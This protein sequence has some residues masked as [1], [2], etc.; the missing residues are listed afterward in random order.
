MLELRPSCENCDKALPPESTLAMICTYECTFCQDCVV[1]VLHNVCPNCG[2]GFQQRPIRPREQLSK[3]PASS[4]KIYKPIKV[5]PYMDRY[6]TIPP[7][8]RWVFDWFNSNP[9]KELFHNIFDYHHHFNQEIID[10]YLKHSTEIS[11]RSVPLLSHM[12][13]AHQIWNAR[14][15]N[16]K[17]LPVHQVHS[18]ESCHSIDQKNHQITI[19][20]LET[21]S[22]SEEIMYRNSAGKTYVNSLKDLLF[23]INNHHT[24][25]RGQIISDLRKAEVNP[26]ITDYIFYKRD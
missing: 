12:L 4:K 3:H 8:E 20:I 2:G 5:N 13:N 1:N 26:P 23:H 9:M 19:E 7:Q 25:H 17:E 18:I 14:I 11:D 6:R 15:M 10:I 21:R 24:H 22:L 16:S